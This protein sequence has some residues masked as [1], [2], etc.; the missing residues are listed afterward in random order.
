MCA[1]TPTHTESSFILIHS[2]ILTCT[3]QRLHGCTHKHA[4]MHTHTNGETNKAGHAGPPPSGCL[5]QPPHQLWVPS[6]I[7]RSLWV[8]SICLKDGK[9]PGLAQYSNGTP[10]TSLLSFTVWKQKQYMYKW[11]NM[12]THSAWC[13]CTACY[14][15]YLTV[16]WGRGDVT[17]GN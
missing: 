12:H 10:T 4:C 15:Q 2:F 11:R 9:Q 17:P 1:H 14:W 3:A 7:N 13:I 6:Y 5:C 8:T 16:W